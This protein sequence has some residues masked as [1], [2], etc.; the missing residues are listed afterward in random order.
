MNRNV[1]IENAVS[2]LLEAVTLVKKE[3]ISV[4][5]ACGRTLADDVFAQLAMPPFNRSAYDGFA[6]RS[7]DTWKAKPTRPVT[8][9]VVGTIMAGEYWPNMLSERNAVRIMTGAALPN[10]A[11]CVINFEKVKENGKSITLPTPVAPWQNV[12]RKGDEVT[13]GALLLR[14]GER[15]TPFHVGILA[16]QGYTQVSVRRRPRAAILSTG[17][18]LT[19]AGAPLIQGR[20]YDSN[21]AV[22]RAQLERD[23]CE[24]T[25]TVRLPGDRAQI[26]DTL[27][28]LS[29]NNDL[30]VTTGGASAG[31]RD[32]MENAL[33]ECGAR[34]LFAHVQM[35]PGSCCFG[36]VL[37]G[38]LILSLSG[39]PSAALTSYFRIMIPAIRKMSGRQDIWLK[40]NILPLRSEYG[41]TC[42]CP[43]I[44]KGHTETENGITRFVAHK[45]QG[46]AMQSSFLRMNAFAELPPTD[47]GFTEGTLVRVFYPEL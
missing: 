24:A 7:A 20:I 44:L 15:L 33:E 45:G 36:A 22:F 42:P 16:A 12:D 39:N 18:E 10:G 17:C 5:R 3:T 29:C 46:N 34:I 1:T 8:L 26:C 41:K 40:E 30:V 9:P 11:D 13:E 37:N 35:K 14:G 4:S 28:Y 2:L 31:D 32:F 23:G 6:L 27:Q 43:R 38:A 25:E 19:E 21:L 47:H